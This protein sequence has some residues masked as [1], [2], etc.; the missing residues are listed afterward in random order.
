MARRAR[1]R[2]ARLDGLAE[3]ARGIGGVLEA[4]RG[5]E[6]ALLQASR[7]A[8][9]TIGP[10]VAKLADRIRA[11]WEVERALRAFA[12]DFDDATADLFVATLLLASERRGP[13]LASVMQDIAASV[14][15]EVRA[16]REVETEQQKP[17]TA[18][19]M[20]TAIT[21]TLLIGLLVTGDYITPYSTPIGQVLLTAY[22]IAF[23]AILGWMARMT[24]EQPIPRLLGPATPEQGQR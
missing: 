20:I 5:I 15:Q 21:T 2:T 11:N 16:R 9:Q 13:G 4:G 7:S 18:A 8:P 1:P 17:R 24:R 19:R 6:Q 10:E 12:D 3:F 22:M 23:L 14:D